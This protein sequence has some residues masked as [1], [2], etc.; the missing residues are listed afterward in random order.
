MKEEP[1]IKNEAEFKEEKQQLSIMIP[2][3][4]E[5]SVQNSPSI[6]SPAL[7]KSPTKPSLGLPDQVTDSQIFS[8]QLNYNVFLYFF[9][10]RLFNVFL[11]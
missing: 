3:E 4:R 9:L 1:V 2:R 7:G 11:F 10:M 5:G 8:V 6:T